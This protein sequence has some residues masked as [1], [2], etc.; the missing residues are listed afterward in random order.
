MNI[1]EL[2][3]DKWEEYLSLRIQLGGYSK[4]M[5]KN[6]FKS[7]YTL[8]KNQGSRIYIGVY[9]NKIVATAKLNIEIKFFDNVAQIEDVVVY[10]TYRK[11]GFGESIVKHLIQVVEDEGNCYKIIL[12][13][14]DELKYFYEKN[15]MK[16]TG[17]SMTKI[18]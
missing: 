17:I 9:D 1:S 15:G 11:R 14:R 12:L 13:T 10:E 18:L 4:K 8:M 3:C 5:D 7:I 6:V 16:K 2:T